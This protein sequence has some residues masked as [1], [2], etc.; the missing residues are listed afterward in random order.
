MSHSIALILN[1]QTSELAGSMDKVQ[2]GLRR[3]E[4]CMAL[5]E[6][7]LDKRSTSCKQSRGQARG[8]SKAPLCHLHKKFGDKAHHCSPPSSFNEKQG[9]ALAGNRR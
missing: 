2:E 1:I 7:N 9:K 4:V 5:V 3:L 8:S 6:G